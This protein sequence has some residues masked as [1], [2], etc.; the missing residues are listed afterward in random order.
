MQV[1][2][3]LLVLGV[4]IT[5]VG[6]GWMFA[7]QR[8][9]SSLLSSQDVHEID[10]LVQGYIRGVDIGPEDASW[11]FAR[12]GVFVYSGGTVTGETQLKEFYAKFRKDHSETQYHLLS[13]LVVKPSPEGATG[14]V[15]MT[16]IDGRGDTSKPVITGFGIYKDTYVKTA[17]GWRIKRRQHVSAMTGAQ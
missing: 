7:Q 2:R 13:N 6:T 10:Q 15:Y 11:V 12:D 8:K 9:Q 14:S 1:S 16:T 4:M 17:A 3:A 5:V